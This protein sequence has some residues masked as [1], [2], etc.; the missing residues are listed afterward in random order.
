[1]PSANTGAHRRRFEAVEPPLHGSSVSDGN[2]L[3]LELATFCVAH[4]VL[5]DEKR[6]GSKRLKHNPHAHPGRTI[7]EYVVA[8]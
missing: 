5:L 3:T 8:A 1:M 2:H 4:G 7:N 6:P